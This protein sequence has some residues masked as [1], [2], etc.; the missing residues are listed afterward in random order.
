LFGIKGIFIPSE[1][2]QVALSRSQ[3]EFRGAES[4]YSDFQL[5]YDYV[6]R[7]NEI[8]RIQMK[9]KTRSK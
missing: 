6:Q 9:V 5:V 3:N 1:F 8:T 4:K 7:H 2:T